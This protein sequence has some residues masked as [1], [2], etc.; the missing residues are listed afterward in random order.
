[1]PEDFY[2]ILGV[3]KNADEAEIKKA[4]RKLARKYHPD[5]NPNDPK[6][7]KRF[8]EIN[9]AY[10]TLSDAKKRAQYD[11]FGAAGYQQG[12]GFGSGGGFG[13]FDFGSAGFDTD[14]G[15]LGDIFN[16]FFG[17]EGRRSAR[18]GRYP[19]AKKGEDIHLTLPISFD[20][21]F[22]GAEKE[23]SYSGFNVCSNCN[24]S[25]TVQGTAPSACRQ[26]GGSGQ[27]QIGRGM[28][29]MAQ[30]CPSCGGAGRAK[31]AACPQCGGRGN[32]PAA[33]H[34]SIKI[35][36]G[37]DNGSKIRI[38]GKGRPGESGMPH[39]DLFIIT[40]VENHPLFDRK[41]NNLHIEI[42][43]TVVEAALGTRIEVPTPEGKSSLK[44]PEATD[45][46]KTF[47]LRGKGFPSLHSTG[48]GDLYVKVKVI[49]PKNL[50]KQDRDILR[51]FAEMHPEDPRINYAGF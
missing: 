7:E 26:C 40:Q 46:G 50:S 6:A 10:Q 23:I 48:R 51:R 28:L 31:G 12:P 13:G 49:T 9:E 2:S 41:G 32:S 17:G 14:S 42:P 19:R 33:R 44:I 47:R 22:N 39:G 11:Q 43:L 38:P 4:Y 20:E 5:V 8:K 18:H 21:A 24:G 36:P 27:I 3:D 30:T 1:M 34:L 45:T 29:K 37:V 16:I 35:P 15:D 25:G